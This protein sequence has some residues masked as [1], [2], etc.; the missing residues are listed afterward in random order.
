MLEKWRRK[1]MKW[2]KKERQK[3]KECIAKYEFQG[4]MMFLKAQPH[5]NIPLS[6]KLR[7][8][9]ESLRN[10][11]GRNYPKGTIAVRKCYFM[12]HLEIWRSILVSRGEG[13]PLAS[14]VL[15]PGRQVLCTMHK[16]TLLCTYLNKI[17]DTW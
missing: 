15:G 17:I 7:Q 6:T 5:F 13:G 9:K 8:Q 16:W 14:S 2:G 10:Y 1:A 3:K 4:M 11:H 12:R